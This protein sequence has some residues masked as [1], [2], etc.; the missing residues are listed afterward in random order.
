MDTQVHQAEPYR[1]GAMGSLGNAKYMLICQH[2]FP[3]F[4]VRNMDEIKQIDHDRAM[5]HYPD[6]TDRC[7]KEH[8]SRGALDFEHWVVN[9]TNEQVFAFLKDIL[10]ADTKKEWTGYRILGTVTQRG[11]PVWTLQLFAKH[12]DTD[13]VEYSD[14]YAPNIK[15]GSSDQDDSISIMGPH[16]LRGPRR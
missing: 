14:Y 7:F 12:P 3:N 4:Y 13:T 5:Q 1:I 16:I 10:K 6:Y 2:N 8:T 15:R 9:A 11:F